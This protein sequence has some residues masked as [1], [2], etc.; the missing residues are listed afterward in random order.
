MFEVVVLVGLAAALWLVYVGAREH[1]RSGC[2][3]CG[4]HYL[5][6][7]RGGWKCRQCGHEWKLEA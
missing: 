1:E 5:R 7:L 6:H 4:G 3:A 2:P